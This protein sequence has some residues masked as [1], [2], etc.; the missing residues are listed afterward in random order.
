MQLLAH[1]AQ[2]QQQLLQQQRQQQQEMFGQGSSSA[3]LQHL[4]KLHQQGEQGIEMI[5]DYST[6]AAKSGAYTI[7]SHGDTIKT[8]A[9]GKSIQMPLSNTINPS[10]VDQMPYSSSMQASSKQPPALISN[11]QTW[12]SGERVISEFEKGHVRDLSFGSQDSP[13]FSLPMGEIAKN[14]VM[15][16]TT[17]SLLYHK[18][19]AAALPSAPANEPEPELKSPLDHPDQLERHRS[20][21]FSTDS[22]A[23]S[24]GEQQPEDDDEAPLNEHDKKAAAA[25]SQLMEQGEKNPPVAPGIALSYKPNT[26]ITEQNFVRPTNAS[27]GLSLSLL[28]VQELFRNTPPPTYE[29][30]LLPGTAGTLAIPPAVVA[31]IPQSTAM[32]MSNNEIKQEPNS[33]ATKVP[34][35]QYYIPSQNCVPLAMQEDPSKYSG[36]NVEMSP[37]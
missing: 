33:P 5:Q 15:T 22:G 30:S 11:Y 16:K 9:T 6:F 25:I 34:P 32:A 26:G 13:I 2:Q 27:Q 12:P 17:T 24:G 19:S 31:Q 23:A 36:N 18:H 35:R 29:Q 3:A 20:R 14:P 28:Q 8:D 7:Y 21:F 4:A 1:S 37:R 10:N